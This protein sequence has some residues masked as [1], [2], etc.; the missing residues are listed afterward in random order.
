M[1][2]PPAETLENLLADAENRNRKIMILGLGSELRGADAVGTFIA[3][4]LEGLSPRIV[5]IPAGIHIENV[6]YAV[7][8]ERPD[9]LILVDATSCTDL[10]EGQWDFFPVEELDT[11]CH[12]THSIPLRLIAEYWRREL[13]ALEIR[14]IGIKIDTARMLADL[15]PAVETARRDIAALFRRHAGG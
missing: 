9:L 4:D 11:L 10:E 3:G 7:K 14:F 12:T 5:S 13:P 15:P 2:S 6:M 8:R 1:A